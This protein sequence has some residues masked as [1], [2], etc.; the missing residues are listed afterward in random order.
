MEILDPIRHQPQVP[1]QVFRVEKEKERAKAKGSKNAETGAGIA[2]RE[3]KP[4]RKGAVAKV[5]REKA[6]KEATEEISFTIF[7]TRLRLKIHCMTL[8]NNQLL[9]L[10]SYLEC[11]MGK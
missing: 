10:G 2:R 9:S 4:P 3:G 1:G 5:G 8:T 6:G 11:A 7:R